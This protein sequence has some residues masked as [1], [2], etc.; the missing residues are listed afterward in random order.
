M[1]SVTKGPGEQPFAP[2]I[3]SHNHLTL[4]SRNDPVRDLAPR[5]RCTLKNENPL[6][7]EKPRLPSAV[8]RPQNKPID[9]SSE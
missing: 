8:L 5:N 6:S 1:E 4:S 7:A 2:T 3:E 9:S